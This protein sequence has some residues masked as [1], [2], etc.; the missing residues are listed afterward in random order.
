MN[1]RGETAAVFDVVLNL[2]SRNENVFW[3]DY[4]MY[5]TGC[6]KILFF[7]TASISMIHPIDRFYG[8]KILFELRSKLW[9]HDCNCLFAPSSKKNKSTV[10][11]FEICFLGDEKIISKISEC[12]FFFPR[13][14][15]F[16]WAKEMANRNSRER[17]KKRRKRT[18]VFFLFISFALPLYAFGVSSF[19]LL[20][21]SF[22]MTNKTV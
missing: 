16:E 6:F 9:L 17:R 22:V 19:F 5:P 14:P 8:S 13:P 18:S 3:K 15:R 2:V 11:N 12:V 20:L 21:S 1:D 10:F 4:Q 7:S